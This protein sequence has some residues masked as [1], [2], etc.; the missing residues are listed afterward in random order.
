M[1]ADEDGLVRAIL[2]DPWDELARAAY[3]DWLEEQGA[4]EHAKLMR[5]PRGTTLDRLEALILQ[6]FGGGRGGVSQVDGLVVGQMRFETFLS[7]AFQRDGPAWMRRHHIAVLRLAAHRDWRGLLTAPALN[8]IRGLGI[9]A[10][11]LRHGVAEELAQAGS[12]AGLYFLELADL[13]CSMAGLKA[14]MQSPALTGLV[15]LGLGQPEVGVGLLEAMG[16]GPLAGRLEH[17]DLA[18]AQMGDRGVEALTRCGRLLGG[19]TTLR[20][21]G[22]LGDASA[23]AIASSP[24][25]GR[26][27]SLELTGGMVGEAGVVALSESSLLPGLHW[28]SLRG[29]LDSV[30]APGYRRLARAAADVPGLRLEV[31]RSTHPSTLTEMREIL[32]PRLIEG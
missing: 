4:P 9:G 15:R 16:D 31:N 3:A 32:G 13:D 2:A 24:Y 6:E 20:L 5:S 27:R 21:G 1:S 17:L 11:T 30:G 7:D 18:G 28:L 25:F 29:N 14:I 23:R 22:V 8:G 19:L 26:L 10:G 12:L